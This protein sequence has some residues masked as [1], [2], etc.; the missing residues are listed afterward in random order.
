[1]IS[2]TETDIIP[3][4]RNLC[5][6]LQP[7]ASSR[8]ITLHFTSEQEKIL[9]NFQTNDLLSGFS[10][11]ISAVID[12]LPDNNSLSLTAEI[13]N[14]ND[15]KYVSIKMR[16]TGINLK[17]VTALLIKSSLPVTLISS[18]TNETT[19]E[20]CYCLSP[21]LDKII[22]KQDSTNDALWNYLS[23][24]NGIKSHFAKLNNPIARL[25]ETKP[26]E[27]VFLT[28]INTCILKNIS[29]EQFD[30][31]ALSNEMTMSRTQLLRR[32]KALTGNSPG[33][34]IKTMRLEKSKDL[35]EI[36]DLTIGEVAYQ[37]G[38]NSPSNFTKVFTE[39]YGITPSQFRRPKPNAT[40]E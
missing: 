26:K 10:K 9:F 14:R 22:D 1:M 19:F 15:S 5:I 16:N 4:L 7:L 6:A 24:V 38:F 31:N 8:N 23:V 30:A 17:M 25:A 18:D 28:K 11:F 21:L 36:G 29:N 33:Y 2:R 3:L 35:L 37:M 32:L 39:K 20:V 13:I 12:F 34:Y 40:N 27:A